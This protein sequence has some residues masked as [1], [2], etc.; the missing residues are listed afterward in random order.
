M[1]RAQGRDR[2]V[3]PRIT[4]AKHELQSINGIGPMRARA[5]MEALAG[6]PAA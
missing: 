3:S 2:V 1:G 4:P 5:I 6:T